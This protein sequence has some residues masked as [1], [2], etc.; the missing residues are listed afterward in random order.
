VNRPHTP[1]VRLAL[2]LNMIA[3]SRIPIYS[4]LSRQFD[5]LLLH[6]GQEANRDTWT[7]FAGK[8]PDARV[9]RAWGMQ[10]PIQ[11]KLDGQAFDIKFIHV[12]PGLIWHLLRFRPSAII[13]NEMGIRSMIAL[14]Y[15]TLF[16]IPVWIWWGGTLHTERN[17]GLSRKVLRKF[18][19]ISADR[20]I[21]YGQTST[22]YLLKLGVKPDRI[23]ESQNAV[24]DHRFI[25]ESQPLWDISPH[26]VVL[27]TGQFIERKGVVALLEAAATVQRNGREFSLLLVGNG[28]DKQRLKERAQS[29]GLKNIHFCPAQTPENMPSVYRSADLLVL[30][31]LEDVWGLVANEAILSNL[32]V[33]CSKYAGCAPELF[34]PE[35]IFSPDDPQ[36][37]A[38]KLDNA[39]SGRLAMPDR[40]RLRI[41][42]QLA[43]ELVED[44]NTHLHGGP[45]PSTVVGPSLRES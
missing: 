43:Q 44:L 13:S 3:P 33:L 41:T 27:Y 24:D 42:E 22:E 18:I 23:F 26:P 16:R 5:L 12:T 9:V 2:L 19:S 38:Q 29:L 20:W 34:S 21:S 32:N 37:F 10:F 30:P 36:D 15:G 31:T 8:L 14:A 25:T 1:K 17:I 4:T 40:T 45:A 11:K 7:D 39:I 35:H 6:G 28:R